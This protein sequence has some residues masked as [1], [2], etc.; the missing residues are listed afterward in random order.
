M[1]QE[2]WQRCRVS[3]P[4]LLLPPLPAAAASIEWRGSTGQPGRSGSSGLTFTAV[5]SRS[6]RVYVILSG[7]TDR[8]QNRYLGGEDGGWQRE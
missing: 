7:D 3:Q 4:G 1:D 5:R 2:R 6:G 8:Y